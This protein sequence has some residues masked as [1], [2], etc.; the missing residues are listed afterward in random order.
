ML[1][2]LFVRLNNEHNGEKGK[3]NCQSFNIINSEIHFY[4]P[5]KRERFCAFSLIFQYIKH[6]S[7][8][9]L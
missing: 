4:S 3:L 7:S 8:P 1:N 6:N 9:L 5:F 2:I